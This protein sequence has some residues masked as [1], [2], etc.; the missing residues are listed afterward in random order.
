MPAALLIEQAGLKGLRVGPAEVSRRHANFLVA[1]QGAQA[2]DIL[3]LADE[4]K[5]RV[6]EHSGV[7]L[8]EEVVRLGFAPNP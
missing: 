8:V 4:V 6:F 1:L 5:H 2:S 3:A 7:Q